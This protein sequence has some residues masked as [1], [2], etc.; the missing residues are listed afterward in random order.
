MLKCIDEGQKKEA[1]QP[2][3]L[4]ALL[5]LNSNCL[6]S[7][8]EQVGEDGG[9]ALCNTAFSNVDL[10]LLLLLR[11]GMALPREAEVGEILAL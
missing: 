2:S 1:V 7:L 4:A 10:A 3:S 11:P 6:R 5:G 9:S 8:W